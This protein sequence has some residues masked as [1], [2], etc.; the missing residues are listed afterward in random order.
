MI[1]AKRMLVGVDFSEPSRTALAFAARLALH[2][3]GELDVLHVQDPLLMTAARNAG[4]DLRAESVEELKRFIH[5]TPPAD[6]C[7][8]D[9][10]VLCG[11]PGKVLCDIAAREQAET[12]APPAPELEV[13]AESVD[14]AASSQ[15]PSEA[16]NKLP[17][18][19]LPML[20]YG[21]GSASDDADSHSPRR[22][23]VTAA[24]PA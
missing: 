6:A 23:V 19:F 8:P 17:E 10:F 4:I 12:V 11:T 15:T 2:G 24:V 22:V 5:D 7:H 1:P 16:A 14:A 13:W 21:H 9:S 20:D 18:E 3:G